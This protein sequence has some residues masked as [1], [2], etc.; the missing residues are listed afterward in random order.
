MMMMNALLEHRSSERSS[1]DIEIINL[2][3][4]KTRDR[5][6]SMRLN[7]KRERKNANAQS[8]FANIFC[9]PNK[10]KTIKFIIQMH[11]AA[12]N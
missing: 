2:V 7:K 10:W 8:L 9:L 12:I 5:A 6:H 11:N 3:S 1:I 4:E